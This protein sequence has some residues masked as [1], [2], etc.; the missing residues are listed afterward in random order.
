MEIK[1]GGGLRLLVGGLFRFS[2]RKRYTAA[3]GAEGKKVGDWVEKE[4][5]SNLPPPHFFSYRHTMK[6][7]GNET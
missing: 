2:E 1:R 4:G 7:V 3:T 6:K 5:V